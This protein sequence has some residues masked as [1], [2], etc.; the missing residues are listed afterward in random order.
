MDARGCRTHELHHTEYVLPRDAVSLG[1]R[2]RGDTGDA[3][4]GQPDIRTFAGAASLGR[5]WTRFGTDPLS[6]LV[7][8][9][10]SRPSDRDGLGRVHHRGP[11]GRIEA[12]R[13]LAVTVFAVHR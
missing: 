4:Y 8:L 1:F 10:S 13:S 11:G 9:Q 7:L 6:P 12:G 2:R 3:R 5:C